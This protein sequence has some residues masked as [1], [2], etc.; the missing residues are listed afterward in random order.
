MATK[1]KEPEVMPKESPLEMTEVL[2]RAGYEH[3]RL[4]FSQPAEHGKQAEHARDVLKALSI[5]SRIR[6]TRAN[7]AAITL[8]MA[9]LM[10]LEGKALAPL[11]EQ[12]TGTSAER[13]GSVPVK[14]L[15]PK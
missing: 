13:F 1:D 4:Y 12:L 11:W 10:G 7:E 9:R 6:A 2:A 8:T 3:A 14:P 5:Y 15:E